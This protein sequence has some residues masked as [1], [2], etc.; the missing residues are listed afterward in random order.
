[1]YVVFIVDE[2]R[3][4]QRTMCLVCFNSNRKRGIAVQIDNDRVV[5][6]ADGKSSGR[7]CI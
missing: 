5:S 2:S 4:R 7:T 3:C 1:M 6:Q